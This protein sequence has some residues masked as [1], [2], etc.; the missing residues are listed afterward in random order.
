MTGEVKSGLGRFCGQCT[1][2]SPAVAVEIGGM[3]AWQAKEFGTLL[4]TIDGA[5]AVEIDGGRAFLAV[6]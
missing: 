4:A 2:R 5:V 3:P 1:R 6:A